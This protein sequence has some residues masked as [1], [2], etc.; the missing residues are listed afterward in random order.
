MKKCLTLLVFTL[1][2]LAAQAQFR[3]SGT[4]VNSRGNDTLTL[5]MPYIA[6]VNTESGIP[7]PVDSR[8]NFDLRL[9]LK[10]QRFAFLKWNRTSQT[11]LLIPGKNLGLTIRDTA[12][13]GMSG[14]AANENRLIRELQLGRTPFFRTEGTTKNPYAALQMKGIKN[15]VINPWLAQRDRKLALVNASGLGNDL[16]ALLAQ[17]ISAEA[18]HQLDYF[19]RIDIHSSRTLIDS[20]MYQVFAAVDPSP[21]TL[22]AGPQYYYF[23]ESYAAY[24][25]MLAMHDYRARPRTAA[26]APLKYFGVPFSAAGALAKTK[27]KHYLD[28]LLIRNITDKRVAE[29]MLAQTI[30]NLAAEK[31]LGQAR[32]YAAELDSLYPQSTYRAHLAGRVAT[33]ERLLNANPLRSA[34]TVLPGYE[35]FTSIKEIL[36]AFKGKVV[37][38]DV[39]GTWCGPCLAELPYLAD[40]QK[41]FAGKD[42][43]F[44]YFDMDDD[45][46]DGQWREFIRVNAM[47]GAHLRKNKT[48]IQ[49][50]WAE[51]LP[52]AEGKRGRYPTY[53][54]FDRDGKLVQDDAKR[55][56]DKNAL[57]RQIEMVLK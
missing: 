55:P 20:V 17:E 10:T 6:R 22:P 40:L 36:T 7:V 34:I 54:I 8:G 15:Q 18:I 13:V 56:S 45:E 50:F 53:F 39:W 11:L 35:K 32:I 37:Y 25:E 44:V 43:A 4:F 24:L 12:V 26:D 16:K 33:M 29:A 28:W 21:K 30:D 41:Q 31:N 27:G 19:A 49:P 47:N 23:I 2:A 14:S 48:E 9:D 38:L 51:L 52:D 42:V 46:K 57:Y 1:T 3:L 5:V